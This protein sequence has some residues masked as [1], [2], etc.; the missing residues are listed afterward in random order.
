MGLA[1]ETSETSRLVQGYEQV[2]AATR[3]FRQRVPNSIRP[4][5]EFNFE[6]IVSIL[7]VVEEWH[8]VS[9]FRNHLSGGERY[10][11]TDEGAS[12]DFAGS[13]FFLVSN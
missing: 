7:Q 6:T 10:F 3:R 1:R 8:L 4:G 5:R 13:G 9:F 12:D 11:V 2:R